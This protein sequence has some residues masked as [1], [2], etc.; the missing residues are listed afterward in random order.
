M[1]TGVFDSGEF[2]AHIVENR[3]F[4]DDGPEFCCHAEE[5]VDGGDGRVLGCE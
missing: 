2:F 1:E 3:D 5:G 4:V